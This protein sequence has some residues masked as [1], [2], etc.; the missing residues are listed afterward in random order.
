MCETVVSKHVVLETYPTSAR[1]RAVSFLLTSASAGQYTVEEGAKF[2]SCQ[3]VMTKKM[4]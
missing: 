3:G 2:N 1:G 4:E